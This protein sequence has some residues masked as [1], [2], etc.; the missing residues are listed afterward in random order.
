MDKLLIYI[1]QDQEHPYEMMKL[2]RLLGTDE[3]RNTVRW[4]NLSKKFFDHFRQEI[5]DWCGYDRVEPWSERISVTDRALLSNLFGQMKVE[6]YFEDESYESL[7]KH[8][9]VCF[10]LEGTEN[11]FC[12]EVKEHDS[13]Y[14]DCINR[15]LKEINEISKKN[16]KNK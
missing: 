2:A 1:E 14:S 12:T 8:L 6:Q 7:S 15:F 3:C 5:L 9:F 13:A 4:N 10:R 16:S 11:S